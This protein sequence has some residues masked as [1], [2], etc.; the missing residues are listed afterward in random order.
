MLANDVSIAFVLRCDNRNNFVL[1]NLFQHNE[2]DSSTINGSQGCLAQRL[3][4]RH[5]QT[6]AD[7]GE[8]AK[9]SREEEEESVRRAAG[10]Q[11]LDPDQRG[12]SEETH[13]QET[14]QHA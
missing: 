7:D 11:G 5:Q 3:P 13:S 10:A 12:H 9:S 14:S 8:V 6:V 4:L 2:A 1:F